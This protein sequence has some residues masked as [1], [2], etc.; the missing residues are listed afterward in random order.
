MVTD[1]TIDNGC[2]HICKKSLVI[3]ITILKNI[4]LNERSVRSG[5][6]DPRF[7]EE[8][9]KSIP[10]TGKKGSVLIFDPLCLHHSEV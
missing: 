6:T 3:Q 5:E 8:I 2:M 1:N 4:F 7:H 10:I 9:K